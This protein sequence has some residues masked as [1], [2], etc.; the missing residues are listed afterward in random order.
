MSRTAS[1]LAGDLERFRAAHPIQV[2]T[3]DGMAWEYFKGGSG[4][5]TIVLLPG[6]SGFTEAYFSHF[7]ELEKTHR[8]L[9][10]A[11]AAVRSVAA[12]VRGILA[13]L[14]HE[15]AGKAAILGQSWGG[16]LA[17][18]LVRQAPDRVDRLILSHTLPTAPPGD[19]E[20]AQKT[21]RM[22]RVMMKLLPFLPWFVLRKLLMKRVS[23]HYAML[24]DDA[25]RFWWNYFEKE[26]ARSTKEELAATYLAMIDFF[27]LSP[28]RPDDLSAWKG[29]I[30]ILESDG[31]RASNEKNRTALKSLYPKA[32]VHTF[33]NSGH[34]A[35]FVRYDEFMKVLRSFLG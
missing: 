4:A 23:V 21:I 30:L 16:M 12:C 14:D 10:I 2:H 29:K 1:D 6:G 33:Q 35:M 24:P 13:I 34:L 26:L 18:V 5:H 15:K 3:V 22:M 7:L 32:K 8:V 11:P 25:F 17:Q 9:A 28:F 20:H 19:E 27:T 31:D